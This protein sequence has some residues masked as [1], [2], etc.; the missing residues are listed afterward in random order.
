MCVCVAMVLGGG[1]HRGEAVSRPEE[2]GQQHKPG[3]HRGA[4]KARQPLED[5]LRQPGAASGLCA[6]FSGRGKRKWA[7]DVL[8]Q[9]KFVSF[10]TVGPTSQ[11]I[12][13]PLLG[14]HVTLDLT[15]H[16]VQNFCDLT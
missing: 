8:K 3:S 7:R 12:Q 11:N 15:P 16:R 4:E 6:L 9:N 10:Y 1:V 14:A 5:F 13:F 2:S